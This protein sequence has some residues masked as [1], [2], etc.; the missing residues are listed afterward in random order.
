MI[1]APGV[2]TGMPFDEYFAYK[3]LSKHNVDALSRSPQH[4]LASLE[5][6]RKRTA[7]MAFG[8]AFHAAVLEP[9][10]FDRWYYPDPGIDRRT[11]AGKAAYD[12][13]AAEGQTLLKSDECDAIQAML[14]AIRSHP[15]ASILLSPE[16]GE[17]EVAIAWI[18]QET[19]VACRARPDFLNHAHSLVIDLKTSTDASY[20]AFAR[21]CATYRYH[22]Q[23]AMYLDGLA[24]VKPQKAFV[25]VAVETEA[26]FGIGC[27]ELGGDDV[28][29]GRTLYRKALRVYAECVATDTWPGYP[30]EVRVLELPAWAR[31][32]P[33]S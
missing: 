33:I 7:A 26:P 12:S 3:N 32:V 20:G 4:Y 31:F 10:E 16:D 6:P 5:H 24:A 29:L 28:A 30:E 22:C 13:A 21:A 11:K 8:A 23:A 15:F 14:H 2:Y 17:A 1:L 27:Y 25:F 18:D 9:D 19:G